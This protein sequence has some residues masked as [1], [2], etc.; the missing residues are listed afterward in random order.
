MNPIIEH[1]CRRHCITTDDFF[2]KN[3]SRES[4]A[5]R[6]EAIMRLQ[7][8]GYR[9]EDIAAETQLNVQ[10]VYYWLHPSRREK[11]RKQSWQTFRVKSLGGPKQTKEQR[12]E[13][14]AAYME[15][16]AKGTALACSRGLSPLY[17]YKLAQAMGA[18]PRKGEL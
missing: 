2:Q 17:V 6:R 18:V 1:I 13:I 9:F 16:R 12:Q 3:R 11:I 14:L 5:A 10:T 4:V 8:A 7:K 15:D